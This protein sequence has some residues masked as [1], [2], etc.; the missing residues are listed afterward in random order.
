MGR[1]QSEG[2]MSRSY[3]EKKRKKSCNAI[4]DFFP[5]CLPMPVEKCVLNAA[6]LAVQ[7]GRRDSVL[8][9][10]DRRISDR[11]RGSRA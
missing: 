3:D 1:V 8:P 6:K 2:G 10:A 11:C 5:Q 7:W 4:D 9:L